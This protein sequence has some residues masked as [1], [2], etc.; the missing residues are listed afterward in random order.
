MSTQLP[1]F[2]LL[3]HKISDTYLYITTGAQNEL[4]SKH[5]T[6][7]VVFKQIFP[8]IPFTNL[9]GVARILGH[10]FRSQ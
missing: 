10:I 6:A 4:M 5:N 8:K 1:K 3:Q 9:Q 7:E 2:C